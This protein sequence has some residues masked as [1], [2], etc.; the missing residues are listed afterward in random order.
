M[1][2]NSLDSEIKQNFISWL[3]LNCHV[4]LGKLPQSEPQLSQL[5]MEL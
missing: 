1:V 3:S 4:S 2:I 5:N